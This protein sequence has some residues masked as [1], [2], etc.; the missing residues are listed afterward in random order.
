MPNEERSVMNEREK[1][2][3]LYRILAP[4]YSPIRPFWASAIISQAEGYLEGVVLPK[5]LSTKASVLDMGCGPGTNL[6]RLLR[7]NLPFTRYVGIDL[8]PTM[9]KW[10]RRHHSPSEGFV[11]ADSLRLPFEACTFDLV[12]STW[13]FSHIPEPSLVID[14]AQRLLRP[15]GWMIVA[16]FTSTLGWSR[17]FLR[18][19]ES[20][21]MMRCVLQEEIQTWPGLKEVKTFAGGWNAVV[22][23][24]KES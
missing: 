8:S 20:L 23:L 14:E 2:L 24:R 18:R 19:I 10:R 1:I 11:V 22:C 16:C 6:T 13:M 17:V 12:L 15:G 5:T 21:F 9:L 4:F 3:H 7:L